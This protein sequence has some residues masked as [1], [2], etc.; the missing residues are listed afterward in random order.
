MLIVELSFTSVSEERMAALP[1]HREN[2]L[3][4]HRE[5]KVFAAG[6]LADRSGAL[7]IFSVERD[8]LDRIL[9]DDPY[10]RS[11]GCTIASIRRWTPMLGVA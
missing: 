1:R 7:L 2:I 4:L 8:E 9:A 6:P 10:F 5:G 3:R 11:E